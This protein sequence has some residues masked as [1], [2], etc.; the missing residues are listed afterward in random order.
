MFDKLVLPFRFIP[1]GSPEALEAPPPDHIRIRARFV[2]AASP[3][4]EAD[5]TDDG[6][7]DRAGVHDAV[8]GEAPGGGLGEQAD[9][10][11]AGNHRFSDPVRSY[12]RVSRHVSGEVYPDPVSA[13]AA[14]RSSRRGHN[15]LLAA[16]DTPSDRRL[17]ATS[18]IIAFR[19]AA[20]A[21]DR[22]PPRPTRRTPLGMKLSPNP[23]RST[24]PIL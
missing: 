21:R 9:D 7:I 18:R 2:P 24:P 23:M 3:E 15:R 17:S 14:K 16:N 6:R 20:A 12:I 1:D 11:P 5:E 10:V 8:G 13:S 19:H 22:R 4:A